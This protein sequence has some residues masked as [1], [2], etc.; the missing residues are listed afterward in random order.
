MKL[1]K[2]INRWDEIIEGKC[3]QTLKCT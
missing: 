1:I 2:V 3:T